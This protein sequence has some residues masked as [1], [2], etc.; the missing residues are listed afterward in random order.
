MPPAAR[1][2]RIKGKTCGTILLFLSLLP[3]DFEPRQDRGLFHANRPQ[4]LGVESKETQNRR[5][6]LRRG[7]R[8]L[9]RSRRQTRVRNDQADI[10]IAIIEASV[11]GIFR[12]GTRVDRTV[13][14]PHD[15]V[16]RAAVLQR[17]AEPQCQFVSSQHFVDKK[18]NGINIQVV[19]H[20]W[21][22]V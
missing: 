19:P 8:T 6:D 5:R 21:P 22:I 10:R 3:L 18:W 15:N 4:S 12:R 13:V 14:R 7:D 9:Q 2:S 20:R 17:I 1:S 11:L 16:G